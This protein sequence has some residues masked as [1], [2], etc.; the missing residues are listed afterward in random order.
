[1][2]KPYDARSR[3]E[4]RIVEKGRW[5]K[6]EKGRLLTHQKGYDDRMIISQ[7]RR[8]GE[9]ALD[10][11]AFVDTDVILNPA[12]AERLAGESL[13]V[14][15]HAPFTLRSASDSFVTSSCDHGA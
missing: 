12:N 7:K 8:P 5:L 3:T 4:Q 13:S 1:M 10:M 14:Q 9:R 6:I 2:A 15:T 11:F